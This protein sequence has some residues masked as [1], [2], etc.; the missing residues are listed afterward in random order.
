MKHIPWLALLLFLTLHTQAQG[1]L[2]AG[3]G[4]VVITPEKNLW[5]AGYASRTAPADGKIHDLYAKTLALEDETGTRSVLITTDLLGLPRTLVS[6]LAAQARAEFYLPRERLLVTFSHTHCGPVL[7]GDQLVDMYGLDAEQ[8]HLVDEYT[9]RLPALL[10]QS[11]REAL[12][13]LEPAQ[14]G[15]G[16]G[17]ATFAMNRR[18]Y[19]T[20]GVVG[21]INPI[22]PVDHDVPVL[23][24]SRP[25]GTIKALVHG[26]AC[27]NTTLSFQKYCGDYAGFSQAYLEQRLPGTLA[28]FVTGCGADANPHPRRSLELAEQYGEELGLAVLQVLRQTLTPVH[29]PIAAGFAEIP[30]QFSAPP[31]R[32]ALEAQLTSANIYEQRRARRLLQRLDR[33]GALPRDYPYAVQFWRFGSGLQMPALAGEVVADYA[34]RLKHELG[35]QNTWVVGYAN[36]FVAYIPS[37]RVLREG[38]YEGGGSMVY[39]GHHGPWAP[40]IEEDIMKAVRGLAEKTQG[41]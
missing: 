26:Y 13:D 34:L 9:A 22:G 35:R 16:I 14:I 20:N 40:S 19:S 3:I 11:V 18:Q 17:Q 7:S 8:Q 21:G 2:K 41:K 33:E 15:W 27:H 36:D 5:M 37:L 23:K 24:V 6:N 25:D 10:L 39:F 28:L 12:A 32:A 38:G 31:D 1:P 30:L 29:G 4:R